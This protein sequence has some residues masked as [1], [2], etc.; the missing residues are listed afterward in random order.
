V[1]AHP[2]TPHEGVRGQG[3]AQLFS[4]TINLAA[5]SIASILKSHL[6]INCCRLGM[7]IICPCNKNVPEDGPPFKKKPSGSINGC[8]SY[9]IIRNTLDSEASNIEMDPSKSRSTNNK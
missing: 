3:K 2:S 1:P 8:I 5:T 6:Y 9:V 7:L 4:T